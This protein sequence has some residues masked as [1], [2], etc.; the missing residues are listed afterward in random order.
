M[1][2][3]LVRPSLGLGKGNVISKGW[4]TALLYQSKQ[5]TCATL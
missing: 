4:F 1:V 2:Y 3:P 5:M